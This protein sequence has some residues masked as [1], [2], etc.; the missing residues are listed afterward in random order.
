MTKSYRL[1]QCV[2]C[3]GDVHENYLVNCT[4]NT[5]IELTEVKLK[6]KKLQDEVIEKSK[7]IASMEREN[8]E[9]EGKRTEEVSKASPLM[10]KSTQVSNISHREI[11]IEEDFYRKGKELERVNDEKIQQRKE[12]IL[13]KK[14]I[15]N[16]EDQLE[17]LQKQLKDTKLKKMA[18]SPD[19]ANKSTHASCTI[20]DKEVVS[21]STQAKQTTSLWGDDNSQNSHVL[22]S[23]IDSKLKQFTTDILDSVTKIVDEKLNMLGN[24][25]QTLVKIPEEINSNCETFKDALTNNI[26]SS[27]AV[28]DLKIV[29]NRNRND[30]LVQEAER[31]RRAQNL[32]IHGVQ[33]VDAEKQK[34]NDE[35]FITSFLVLGVETAPESI[36]RLGKAD[37]NKTRPL[38]IKLRSETEKDTIMSHLPNL[39]NSE[40]MF[41]R[42][43]VTEDHTIEE[44]QEIRR[45]VDESKEKN[46]NE[47]NAVWKV[48]GDQKNGWRL[49]KFTKRAPP[50]REYIYIL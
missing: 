38:K 48:R 8:Q 29:L 25:F 44:R 47:T 3:V 15:T 20:D 5:N 12:N 46:R 27:S 21:K 23:S 16:L 37:T 7:I 49:V 50:S 9:A 18:K 28:S 19:T 30:Q 11:N 14:E 26:P 17:T 43:S 45:L 1:Y 35:N 40:D 42:I 32:I 41:R 34:E 39:K 6:C 13:F 10:S 4:Q 24:H 2:T 33:E 36:V 22:D 31:K